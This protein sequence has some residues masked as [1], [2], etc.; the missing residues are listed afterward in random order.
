MLKTLCRRRDTFA[1]IQCRTF[2][3]SS[4]KD[5]L[6]VLMTAAV[7]QIAENETPPVFV[8]PHATLLFPYC[9]GDAA[10]GHSL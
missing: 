4:R 8:L 2:A 7:M 9:H 6:F 3:H 5:L 10:G 1:H